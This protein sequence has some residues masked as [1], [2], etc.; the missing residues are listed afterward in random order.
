MEQ[1]NNTEV[2]HVQEDRGMIEKGVEYRYTEF[3]NEIHHVKI[4]VSALHWKLFI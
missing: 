4:K 2:V 3:P 1:G